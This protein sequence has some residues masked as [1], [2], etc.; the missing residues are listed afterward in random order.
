M[1]FLKALFTTPAAAMKLI[2]AGTATLDNAFH[3]KE[4]KSAFLFSWL[5]A[6]GPTNLSRRVLAF[7]VAIIWA[8]SAL[9]TM[10]FTAIGSEIAIDLVD[11][12]SEVVNK[13][14]MVVMLFYFAPHALAA[15][16]GNP[17]AKSK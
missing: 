3:T 15:I 16:K 7:A 9:V 1:G 13:G 11:F 5:K 4:E 12:M 8:I 6:T 17:F 14:F 2:D 10:I